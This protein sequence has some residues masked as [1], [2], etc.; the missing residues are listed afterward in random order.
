MGRTCSC[1]IAMLL[2]ADAPPSLCGPQPCT[3][4]M[5][6][7]GLSTTHLS[8]SFIGSARSCDIEARY[9]TPDAGAFDTQSSGETAHSPKSCRKL[10]GVSE[11]EERTDPVGRAYGV[12]TLVSVL[13]QLGR[14]RTQ[15]G[16]VGL[17][18][19]L[20]NSFWGSPS[21]EAETRRHRY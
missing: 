1:A 19:I 8:L 10:L 9:E 11:S 3:A 6:Q 13:D 12:R 5:G 14:L 2:L 18:F 21:N 7:P 15:H 16:G 17:G 4:H 20:R